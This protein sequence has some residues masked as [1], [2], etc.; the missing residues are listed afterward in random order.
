V[1]AND[2]IIYIGIVVWPVAK[3][4]KKERMPRSYP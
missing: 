3:D 4:E 2:K 1:L